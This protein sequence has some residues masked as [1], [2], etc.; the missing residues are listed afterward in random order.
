LQL[1]D[2]FRETSPSKNHT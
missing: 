2:V 1:F